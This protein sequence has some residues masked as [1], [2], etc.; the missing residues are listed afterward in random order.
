[1]V[2][3]YYAVIRCSSLQHHGIKGQKWG[4]RRYQN[5]DGS[6][7]EE[8]RKRYLKN[9]VNESDGLTKKGVKEFYKEQGRLDKE[10]TKKIKETLQSPSINSL[11]RAFVKSKELEGVYFDRLHELDSTTDSDVRNTL[12]KDA[13][14]IFKKYLQSHKELRKTAISWFEKSDIMDYKYPLINNMKMSVGKQLV[15][16]LILYPDADIVPDAIRSEI[17]SEK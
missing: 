6:L 14:A 17:L 16:S 1:M 11:T 3:E 10:I 5:E 12:R 2:N 13:D 9:G 15:E 7:T 4:E 8:G